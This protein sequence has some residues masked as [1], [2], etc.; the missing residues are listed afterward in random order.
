MRAICT[1][2][3]LCAFSVVASAQTFVNWETPHVHPADMTPDGSKLV[4]VNTADNRLE[5]FSL[6]S[7]APT[8]IGSVLVG[9]DPVSVRARTNTEVWVVNAISDDVSIVDLETMNVKQTI[10]VGDDPADVVFAGTPQRAFVSIRQFNQVVVLSTTSPGGAQTVLNIEGESPKALATDG[11]NVYVAIFESGNL[12]TV[13][14]EVVAS[15][16]AN[17]YPGNQNPPPNNGQFFN[18][19]IA[20]VIPPPPVGMIVKRDAAGRWMDDNAHDWSPAVDWDQH[21]HDVAIINANSLAT[22]YANGLMEHLMAIAIRPGTGEVTVVGT[23]A[24]NEVRFEPVVNGIFVRPSTARFDPLNPAPTTAIADL[25]PH[26][27]Y[28]VPNNPAIR[29]QSIGDPRAIVWRSNGASAYVAGMGSNNVIIM[30]GNGARLGR[31]DVGQGPTGLVLDEA[32]NQLYV[33]NKFEASISV[34]NTTTNEVAGTVHYFD[35]SPAAIKAGRPQ[36]Y[37]THKTSGLGQVSCASC[38]IDGRMDNLSWDL[39]NP[40]GAIKQFNQS[41]NFGLVGGCENWHPMKGPMTTQSLQGIAGTEPFHWRGDREDLPAFNGAF[42]SLLGADSSLSDEEMQQFVDFVST[43]KYPP[44]PY[45]NK[46]NSLPSAFPN[47]GNPANGQFLFNTLPVDGGAV[48]CAFCHL[49][50]TGF[51]FTVNSGA[52]LAE[53][54]SFKVPHLRNMYEKT[55]F[56]LGTPNNNRGFGFLHD[57]SIDTMQNFLG[58]M[59]VFTFQNQQQKTDIDAYMTCFS[60]ETHAAVGRQMTIANGSSLSSEQVGELSFMEQMA[61]SGDVGLVARG[62]LN[63]VQRGFYYL[64]GSI[65]QTDRQA[66]TIP[67][68][69]LLLQVTPGSELT[70][71]VVPKG[72]EVRIGVDRDADG[73]FDQDELA[74][75]TDPTDP[76]SNPSNPA[77]G[78]FGDLNGDGNVGLQDIITVLQHFGQRDVTYYE[79]DL[80]QNGRVDLTDLVAVLQAY[81]TTC[82]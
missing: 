13:I 6:A 38:H 4:V 33:I 47:G 60:I 39:G 56:L 17:P 35:P 40:A 79:G 53:P 24:I 30:D 72:S 12:T 45:R 48:T 26:L 74:A 49:P 73:G 80:N 68:T 8:P 55:G 37:D 22:T 1:A 78:L 70:L 64:G 61:E 75:C 57:G 23:E 51:A 9:L 28:S 44:N 77:S 16:N 81:G 34:V 21:D 20:T 46:D 52:V 41:C 2:L 63:G 29:D 7:G 69:Q 15:S 10:S 62:R 31:I 18:P 19:P 66:E 32:R 27:D 42:T 65:Y 14:T 25:N 59:N 71:T 54:Q 50:P 5:V 82:H 36:L 67:V 11:T 58:F 3:I 76:G 43:I